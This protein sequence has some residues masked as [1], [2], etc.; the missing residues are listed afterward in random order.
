MVL[1]ANDKIWNEV[2]FLGLRGILPDAVAKAI[3]DAAKPKD[4]TSVG[5]GAVCVLNGKQDLAFDGDLRPFIGTSVRMVKIL[6][7]GLVDV[8]TMDG[9]PLPCPVP[10]RNLIGMQLSSGSAK[11]I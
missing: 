2:K 4:S 9:R 7:S 10:Q 8:E 6:K 1:A 11:T 3:R 5:I